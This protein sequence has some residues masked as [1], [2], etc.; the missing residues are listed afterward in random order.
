MKTSYKITQCCKKGFSLKKTTQAFLSKS[1][2]IVLDFRET[3]NIKTIRKKYA[4]EFY[5][6]T[7]SVTGIL[8]VTGTD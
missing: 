1:L 6:H 8:P 5:T 2:T 3:E 4:L 7:K